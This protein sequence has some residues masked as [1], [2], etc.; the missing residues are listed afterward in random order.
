MLKTSF[1][2]LSKGNNL[3]ST[4]HCIDQII[5]HL[6]LGEK[7]KTKSGGRRR[8]VRTK[9]FMDRL[10]DTKSSLPYNKGFSM[11]R[12]LFSHSPPPAD[13][14][15]SPPRV[16]I[17][18]SPPPPL[19]PSRP[20]SPPRSA[21]KPLA[22]QPGNDILLLQ[23]TQLIPVNIP[24]TGDISPNEAADEVASPPAKKNRKTQVKGKT[25]LILKRFIYRFIFGHASFFLWG[26]SSSA[27]N[28]SE[29]G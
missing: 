22:S 24:G 6:N 2:I 16:E 15:Q 9:N 20:L 7:A 4:L 19:Q 14:I 26:S 28:N 25:R 17:V 27:E 5:I 10:K 18:Q 11:P 23:S 13:T 8:A 3:L 29:I 1:A 12:P 21:S